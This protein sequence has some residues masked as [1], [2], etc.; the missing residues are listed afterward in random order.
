[1]QPAARI[2]QKNLGHTTLE[3]IGGALE[4]PMS[5]SPDW[6]EVSGEPGPARGGDDGPPTSTLQV[7]FGRYG[8]TGTGRDTTGDISGYALA[9][10]PGIG[11]AEVKTALAE[12]ANA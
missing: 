11:E 12:L 4:G 6:D 5:H 3:D 2:R 7:P 1:M 9:L 8:G 10:Q